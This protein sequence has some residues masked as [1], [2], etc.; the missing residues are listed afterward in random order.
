V[1]DHAQ[2][3]DNW[4]AFYSGYLLHLLH[5][6]SCAFCSAGLIFF[7]T[8]IRFLS[9]ECESSSF[10]VPAAEQ[11]EEEEEDRKLQDT[12]GT[13]NS[14][15]MSMTEEP[16]QKRSLSPILMTPPSE[17]ADG[18][19]QMLDAPGSTDGQIQIKVEKED[20]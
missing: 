16:W 12:E 4:C 1:P 17:H 18:T 7:F 20:K 11:L 13:D 5:S 9:E 14:Q 10:D 6:F 3:Y 2:L 19:D 8:C 15:L